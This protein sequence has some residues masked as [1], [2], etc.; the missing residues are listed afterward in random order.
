MTQN[1]EEPF[2]YD[3]FPLYFCCDH[4]NEKNDGLLIVDLLDDSPFGSLRNL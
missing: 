2:H 1:W 3:G 4:L